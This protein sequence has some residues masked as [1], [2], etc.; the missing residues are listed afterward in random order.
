[1]VHV[2]VLWRGASSE[3][4]CSPKGR[5]KQ[6]GLTARCTDA[7]KRLGLSTAVPRAPVSVDVSAQLSGGVRLTCMHNA[8]TSRV[9]ADFDPKKDAANIKKHGVSL[10]RATACSAISGAND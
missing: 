5:A 10:P 7:R 8:Y 1:L 2:A 6:C 4:K 9:S 3:R